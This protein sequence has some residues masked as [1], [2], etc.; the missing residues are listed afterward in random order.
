[1][2]ITDEWRT[3]YKGRKILPT[4]DWVVPNKKDFKWQFLEVIINMQ[5]QTPQT[6]QIRKW[7]ADRAVSLPIVQENRT[8]QLPDSTREHKN[9]TQRAILRD[10]INMYRKCEFV[11][12]YP[13]KDAKV[14]N[15]C[16]TLAKSNGQVRLIADLRNSNV[17]I[18]A[19][20]FALPNIYS[21]LLE[22]ATW[23]MKFD[24]SNAFMHF[25][26]TE[27]MKPYCC[28]RDYKGKI[29]TWNKLPWGSSIAPYV[30]QTIMEP[31]LH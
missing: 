16:I 8:G 27:D 13:A 7:I 22:P 5:P 1:M 10:A 18:I 21:V 9:S 6:K 24:L 14:I 2:A 4:K 12:D 30:C 17:F 19:P 28:F 3:D 29:M 15:T 25:D 23:M 31:V 20:K 26:I 11:S